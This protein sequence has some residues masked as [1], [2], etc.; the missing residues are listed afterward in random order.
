[1]ARPPWT[2][3]VP[4]VLAFVLPFVQLW[5]EL[6]RE[7]S[8]ARFGSPPEDYRALGVLLFLIAALLT[9][10]LLG[11]GLWRGSRFVHVV[12]ILWWLLAEA[13]LGAYNLLINGYEWSAVFNF[14]DIGFFHG[15]LPIALGLLAVV[16]L[17][18]PASWR[19]THH[20]GLARP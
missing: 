7:S 9:A 1:M 13:G 3:I 8:A 15:A 17:I 12:A 10:A 16:L 20:R 4:I 5:P 11:R 6:T 19:W 2:V 18:L 14:T